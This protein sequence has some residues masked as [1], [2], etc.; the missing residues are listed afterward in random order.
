MIEEVAMERYLWATVESR[1]RVN[2]LLG[3]KANGAEQ[4][5]ELE[6]ADPSRLP[7]MVD[8]FERGAL[9]LET[10]SAL[11]LL[12]ISS[13]EE[14]EIIG[15]TNLQLNQRFTSVLN[16]FKDVKS[17]MKCYWIINDG[18]RER[19]FIIDLLNL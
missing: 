14:A 10:R 9:D 15:L 7:E 3:L 4:D 18:A 1:T 13:I 19:D 16:N 17:R 6:L 5:W 2:D 11:G 12:V 8:L